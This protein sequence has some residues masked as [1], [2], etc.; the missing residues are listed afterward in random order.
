MKRIII[1]TDCL[2]IAANELRA[3]LIKTLDVLRKTSRV[4]IEPTVEVEKFSIINAT[5]LI[6]LVAEIYDPKST[7][8]LVVVNPLKTDRIDRARIVGQTEN[9]FIFVGENTGSLSWLL[10]D[11][12]IKEIYET[13]KTGLDGQEFVSFGGKYIHAPIAAKA[14]SGIPLRK[15]GPPFDQERI[16][17]LSIGKGTIVHIDNFGVS[18]LFME[19]PSFPEGKKMT[20]S[21]N[22]LRLDAV[23]TRSMKNLPDGTLA[24]FPGSSLN[25][26]TEIGIVRGNA[27]EKFSL[28]VGDKISIVS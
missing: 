13:T 8:F 26:L 15:L 22:G 4:E 5:F 27:A 20:V 16:T 2:D 10:R 24:V 19:T 23:F 28:K 3:T 18:K 7:V 1:A 11:F 14:A 9:G 17:Y 12:G 6:R 25:N 21:V